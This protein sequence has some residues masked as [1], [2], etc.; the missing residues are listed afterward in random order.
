MH[1]LHYYYYFYLD[2]MV[3]LNGIII[4]LCTS[5]TMCPNIITPARVHQ[6]RRGE[7]VAATAS[8]TTLQLLISPSL[9]F[10]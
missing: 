10:L 7:T 9:G 2:A 3:T 4:L 1:Q 6:R 8:V 5:C